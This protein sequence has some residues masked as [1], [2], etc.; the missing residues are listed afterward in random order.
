MESVF[1]NKTFSISAENAH[2]VLKVSIGFQL[3]S[4]AYNFVG[5][6]QSKT[7][8]QVNVSAYQPMAYQNQIPV[9]IVHLINS[10]S[11]IIVSHVR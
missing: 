4:N 7:I 6:I 3:N 10:F 9:S 1:V 11:T 8:L 5:K 2:L